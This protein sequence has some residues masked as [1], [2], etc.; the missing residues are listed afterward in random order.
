M[1]RSI[2]LDYNGVLVD[3]ERVHFELLRD[4][5]SEEGIALTEPQYD[6]EYLGFDDRGCF[7]TA[8]ARAGQAGPPARIDELIAR[9]AARYAGR[10][11][12]GLKLFPG[13]AE[14]VVALSGRWPLAVCSGA[15][16]AEIECGLDR[17]GVRDRIEAIIAA[18]DTDRCKPDPEGYFLAL[19]ALRSL[20][21]ED[22]EAAHCLVVEDSLAGVEAGKAAG[23]WV[24]AVAHTYPAD[25]LR[26]AGADAVLDR[27]AGLTP[28]TIRRLFLPDVSP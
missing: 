17:L 16:R 1:I 21:H 13:A 20:G 14:A 15:L 11:E 8:L 24:V 26:G 2:I 12:R 25:A 10:A 7:E 5:L 27:L 18:E 4:V 6:A 22:L 3:D 28:E 23:M 19:D 9:K